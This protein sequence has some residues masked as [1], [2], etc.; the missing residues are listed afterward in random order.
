MIFVFVYH[1]T[2]SFHFRGHNQHVSGYCW[3]SP[4]GSVRQLGRV[5][6]TLHLYHLGLSK[7]ATTNGLVDMSGLAVLFI[8]Y[9]VWLIYLHP[10]ARFPG[11]KGAAISNVCT[12]LLYLSFILKPTSDLCVPHDCLWPLC[13]DHARSARKV[14]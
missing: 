7:Q 11:P 2:P 1:S 12:P 5:H 8:T 14:R 6:E 4:R 3:F 13:M 10:F 9:A